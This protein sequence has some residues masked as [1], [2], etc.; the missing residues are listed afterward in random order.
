MISRGRAWKMGDDVDAGIIMQLRFC[1][2]TGPEEFRRH[3]M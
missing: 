3:C 2:K 1:D